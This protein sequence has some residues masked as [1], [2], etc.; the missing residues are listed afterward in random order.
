MSKKL[1]KKEKRALF[2]F[3]QKLLQRFGKRVLG[4]KLFGSRARGDFRKDSDIDVLIVLN[5]FSKKE[6][7]LILK[8]AIQILLKYGIDISPHIYSQKEYLEE[9][10]LPTVFFQILER[11]AISL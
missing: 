3:K 9:R 5:S 7:N 2:E 10:K 11:E 4:L 8:L 6:R 1:N